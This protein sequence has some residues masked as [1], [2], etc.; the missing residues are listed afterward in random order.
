[1]AQETVYFER[2]GAKVTSTRV[3]TPS[4]TFFLR[5]IASVRVVA[6]QPD[7]S[8]ANDAIGHRVIRVITPSMT[9]FLRNIASVRV[10]AVQPD[11]SVANGVIGLGVLTLCI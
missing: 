9:F 7:N 5:N 8:V 1:M 6:V 11:N 4:M 2:P 10:V 3:I